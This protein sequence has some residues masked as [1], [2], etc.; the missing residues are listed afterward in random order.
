MRSV[1][2]VVDERF[3]YR[4]LCILEALEISRPDV[5]ALEPAVERFDVG[6]VLR[7]VIG[8]EFVL[9]P[10]S[11]RGLFECIADVLTL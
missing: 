9:Q 10:Q 8:D 6:I 7:L 2:V 4:G 3:S 11:L 5:F 1:L